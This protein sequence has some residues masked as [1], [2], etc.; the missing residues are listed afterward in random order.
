MIAVSLIEPT[1]TSNN[2]AIGRSID[3]SQEENYF[4][5]PFQAGPVES[6]DAYFDYY[7]Y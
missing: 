7:I 2:S 6:I 5:V 1:S 3:G 4:R